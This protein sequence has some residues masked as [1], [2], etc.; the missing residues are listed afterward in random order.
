MDERHAHLVGGRIAERPGNIDIADHRAE[1]AADRCRRAMLE[2]RILA[3]GAVFLGHGR[4]SGSCMEFTGGR[5]PD[6]QHNATTAVTSPALIA[7]NP[8]PRGGITCP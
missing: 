3:S 1:R 6:H 4:I 2:R 5:P 8:T 7:K